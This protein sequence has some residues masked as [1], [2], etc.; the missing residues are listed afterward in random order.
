[1]LALQ[2]ASIRKETRCLIEWELLTGTSRRSRQRSLV[3]YRY[4]KAEWRI[5]DTFMKMNRSHTVPLSKQ[6]LRVSQVMEPVSRH[7]PWVFPSIRNP[8]AYAPA[9]RERR[10]YPYGVRW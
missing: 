7:R 5:P 2:N 1:M 3:R 6:A 9:D 4:E 8:G 10:A